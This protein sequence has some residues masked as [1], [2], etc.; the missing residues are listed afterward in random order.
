MILQPE[1]ASLV[2]ARDLNAKLFIGAILIL[3]AGG[4]LGDFETWHSENHL[5][6][7]CY[8]AVALLASGLKVS[9]PGVTGTLS[10]VFLFNLIGI[11]ELTLQET[12]TLGCAA[13]LLQSL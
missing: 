8:L 13:T 7:A 12:L 5:R 10:V 1:R 6:F 2:P 4:L 11:Q 9:L 3:G